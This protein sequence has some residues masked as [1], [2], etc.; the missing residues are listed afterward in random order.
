MLYN[1]TE[2]AVIGW[3]PILYHKWSSVETHF[4]YIFLRN[5]YSMLFL[6]NQKQNWCVYNTTHL[7][8]KCPRSLN[9]L[10]YLSNLW[11]IRNYVS[12]GLAKIN[13]NY[14]MIKGTFIGCQSKT[15]LPKVYY[16]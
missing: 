5:E 10:P 7:L 14:T 12:A 13:L 4:K 8:Q 6:K 1:K 2:V 9:G 15:F 3:I 11:Y 16:L